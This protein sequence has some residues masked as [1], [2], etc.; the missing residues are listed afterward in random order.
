MDGF[1]IVLFCM[2]DPSGLAIGATPIYSK[3]SLE[4]YLF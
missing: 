1:L 3:S 2:L 4:F